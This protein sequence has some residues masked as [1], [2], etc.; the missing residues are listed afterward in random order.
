MVSASILAQHDSERSRSVMDRASIVMRSHS[1]SRGTGFCTILFEGPFESLA[2]VLKGRN[3]TTGNDPT[4]ET[5]PQLEEGGTSNCPVHRVDTN[6]LPTLVESLQFA[7]HTSANEILPETAWKSSS[8]AVMQFTN[9]IKDDYCGKSGSIGMLIF[10]VVIF[11]IDN[12]FRK[13]V[14]SC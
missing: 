13:R 10:V 11:G 1:R 5:V 4:T 8:L 2:V 12:V 7:S 3:G 9:F 6:A 14:S